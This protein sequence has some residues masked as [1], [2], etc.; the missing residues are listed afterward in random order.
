MSIDPKPV[1]EGD[2]IQVQHI[3]IEEKPDYWT[4]SHMGLVEILV[5]MHQ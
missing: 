1:G 3:Q 2:A 5:W 4:Q